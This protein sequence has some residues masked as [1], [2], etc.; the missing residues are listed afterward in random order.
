MFIIMILFVVVINVKYFRVLVGGWI[1][2]RHTEKVSM[3]KEDVADD[4]G[5]DMA[6]K[7]LKIRGQEGD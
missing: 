4:D 7:R 1:P 3:K 6:G 5:E 2:I